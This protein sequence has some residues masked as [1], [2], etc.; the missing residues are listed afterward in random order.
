VSEPLPV[1][2]PYEIHA[3]GIAASL[4]KTVIKHDDAFLV[5]DPW[6]DFSLQFQGDLGFFVGGTRFLHFL[7]LRLC[8]QRPLVLGRSISDD[9]LQVAV[10]LTN[11]EIPDPPGPV[12]SNALYIR[13]LLTLYGPQLFE[14]FTITSYLDADVEVPLEL[15][16]AADYADIFEVRGTTRAQ[17]GHAQAPEVS[18]QA[19]RLGYCGRDGLRRSTELAF[20][21]EPELLDAELAV[22]RLR[23]APQRPV[24]LTLVVTA[25]VAGADAPRPAGVADAL[26]RLRDEDEA[27]RRAMARITTGNTQLNAM[28]ARAAA[29]LRMLQTRTADGPVTYAGIPWFATVF[30]RDSLITA[31]EILPFTADVAAST[32][33]FLARYQ[34]T[35]DDAF[36]DAEPGKILHELRAGEMANCREIPFIPYYGS[37]DATP[38]FLVLLGEYVRW[39]GD[40]A[41]ARELWAPAERAL[42]WMD[43]PGDRDGDGYL[44]YR[45]RSPQGLANQGWKDAWDAVMHA[46]GELAEAPIALAEVQGYQYA[47][48]LAFGYLA[49]L[50]GEAGRGAA[51]RARAER[52]RRRFREDFWMP[53]DGTYALALDGGK[54]RCE[55]VTSNAAHCLW[56]G[57]APVEHALAVSKRLL[58]DDVFTGWGLR[59]LSSREARYNPMSYH[60]G[61]VWPHDNAMAAAGFRRY[62]LTE[63]ILTLTTGIFEA[64]REFEHGRLPELFCGFPRQSGLGVTRY[65]VACSPQAWAAGA[66]FQLLAACLGLSAEP[67]E[68]RVTLA[69]PVLPAWLPWIEIHDLQLGRSTLDLRIVQ[70]REG[71]SVELIGRRGDIELLVRR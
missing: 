66:L 45:R 53:E 12:A 71:A 30:G 69:S 60:N 57:I 19:V 43:G 58:A 64:A 54:Q 52:L 9:N 34:A 35:E 67:L 63:P 39:T 41:L 62:G 61:S 68:N 4:P 46:S 51:C 42:G 15:R 26:R 36:L 14:T 32:L 21:A 56:A 1:A 3:S 23:L 20:G 6:G 8:R 28:L 47:A 10:D 25:E 16:F 65:P 59:T 7:E 22:F 27:K 17:R 31:L 49:D 13:R 18:R 37:V 38:L 29:D 70:G 2:H 44:E 33:R 5:A 24:R 48:R 11:A 40:L 50:L 55:V